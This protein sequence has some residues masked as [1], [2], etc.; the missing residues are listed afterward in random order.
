MFIMMKQ[1]LVLTSLNDVKDLWALETFA[2][3]Q[4]TILG[5][6]FANLLTTQLFSML[7]HKMCYKV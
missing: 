6:N 1:H 3:I 5:E 7:S 2:M 4:N